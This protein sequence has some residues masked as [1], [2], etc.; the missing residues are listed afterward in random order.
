GFNP[1]PGAF[2]VFE[3]TAPAGAVLGRIYTKRAS[4][5]FT[6]AVVAVVNNG[7][8]AAPSTNTLTIN[9]LDATGTPGAFNAATN[10]WSGWPTVG[11]A[12]TV[13]GPV[14]WAAGRIN[15]AIT[16]PATAVRNARVR[17]TQAGTGATGCSPDTFR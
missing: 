11:G 3:T 5:N 6:L 13:T 15:V 4:V 2:N 16:A 17:V 12:T 8:N 7:V 10:C 9:V 1:S 14:G